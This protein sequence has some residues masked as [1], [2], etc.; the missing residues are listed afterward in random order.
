[1]PSW[2]AHPVPE[3][4]EVE[5]LAA[6]LR[7]TASGLRI[8]RVE[9][10][11]INALKTFDPPVSALVGSRV[12]GASRRGKF[13]DVEL[14]DDDGEIL[15]LVTHLARAGWL[16]WRREVPAAPPKPGKGP[17]AFRVAF[18]DDDGVPAGGF[19]LTEA[20]TQ[21]RLAVYVVRDPS[22]LEGIAR[23]GPEPLDDAFTQDVLAA[24]LTEA[25]GKQLKGVLRSQAIIA[26]IGNAYS[27]DILHAARLSPFKAAGKLTDV[28]VGTLHTAIHDVLADA[29]R[30]SEGLGA[31]DLKAEKKLGMRVHGRTGQPCPVCGDA[32]RE[33]S[34]ADSSLQYCATCQ[35]GGS[36]LADRRMSKLLK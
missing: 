18:V 35:T 17:L 16:H 11:A 21:K 20:G 29:V 25:G 3:L 9:L 22:T 34:F 8:A 13:L 26:G 32:V 14:V 19:D 33:V 23:L 31:G 12:L 27:D 5:S 28:E 15:H 30:R 36:P 24:I 7:A 2:Q 6:Y 10:A 4:P 1:M